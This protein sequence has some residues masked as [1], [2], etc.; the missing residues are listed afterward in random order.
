[1]EV[2]TIDSLAYRELIS[3]INNIAK[4]I[5][6]HQD[7]EIN[8]DE[9]WVDSYD[10]CTFLKISKRTLQRLRSKGII[11]YS[12]ISGKTYY[13]IAEIKR[14]L[15]DRKIKSSAECMN[16]LVNNYKLH[17]EQRQLIKQDK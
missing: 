16:E 3:K 11:S 2:I 5:Y 10:V 8:P 13:T 12:I 6:D 15:S 7:D 17:A 1:M 9:M 14:M 4:F